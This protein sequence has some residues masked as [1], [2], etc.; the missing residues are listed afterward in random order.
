LFQNSLCKFGSRFVPIGLPLQKPPDLLGKCINLLGSDQSLPHLVK[1]TIPNVLEISKQNDTQE[2]PWSGA[3]N[4]PVVEQ[5]KPD[6]MECILDG[7][8]GQFLVLLGIL[9]EE[10]LPDHNV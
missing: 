10:H 9:F 4:S 2:F 7:Y 6:E 8:L 5:S 1:E 3:M